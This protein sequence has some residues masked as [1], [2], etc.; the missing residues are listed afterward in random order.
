VTFP[1]VFEP[2]VRGHLKAI[3]PVTGDVKWQVPFPSPNIS[4]TLVTAGGLVFAGQLTGEFM[5]FDA[6][7]GRQLWSFQMPSGI[8]GQPVT[9]ER[10]GRQYVT[11]TAGIGGVY[12][13]KIGDPRLQSVPP[14]GSLWTFKLFEE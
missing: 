3:D 5:A 6:S 13:L 11:V 1:P 10:D 4:G 12:A 2:G 8:S 14:G 7:S 9:W